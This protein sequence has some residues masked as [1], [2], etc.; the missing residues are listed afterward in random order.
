NRAARERS[1]G[2]FQVM[3]IDLGAIAVNGA[4][5]PVHGAMASACLPGEKHLQT[6]TARLQDLL[7]FVFKQ[8]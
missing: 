4:R 3:A 7:P 2:L 6:G 8:A 1:S 5:D